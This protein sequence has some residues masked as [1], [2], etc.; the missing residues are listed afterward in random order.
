METITQVK[1]RPIIFSTSMVKAILDG[2]KDQTRRTKGLEKLNER[3]D[4]WELWGSSSGE[5]GM[6]FNYPK[7]DDWSVCF[8]NKLTGEILYIK[9]PFGGYSNILWVRETFYKTLAPD[10][11]SGPCYMFKVSY[12]GK[13][14]FDEP[15]IKWM[16][17]I[18]MP[19]AACRIELEIKSIE[20][21]RLHDITEEDAIREKRRAP[22]MKQRKGFMVNLR[23]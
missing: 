8:R 9:S 11:V 14:L 2:T 1:E 12:D 7:Q 17:A 5:T 10:G 21:E 20:V 16:P 18:Y 13:R 4:D 19:K 23:V 3:P 22:I 6:I 15:E